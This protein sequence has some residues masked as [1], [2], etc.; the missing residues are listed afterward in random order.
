MLFGLRCIKQMMKFQY[1]LNIEYST[2]NVLIAIC[3]DTF[4][5]DKSSTLTLQRSL[6]RIEK[7]V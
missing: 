4:F 6:I 5:A 1:T 3:S 2:I 7:S